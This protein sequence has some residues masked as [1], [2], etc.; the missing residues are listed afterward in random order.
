MPKLPWYFRLAYIFCLPAALLPAVASSADTFKLTDPTGRVDVQIVLRDSPCVDKDVLEYLGENLL[1]DR[2]FKKADL[3]WKG[4][5]FGACYGEAHGLV[6]AV[7]SD[8]RP[9][10]AIPRSAFKDEKI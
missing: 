8:K 10:K 3:E 5:T 6:Y 2:K 4:E 1:D 9:I 7:G